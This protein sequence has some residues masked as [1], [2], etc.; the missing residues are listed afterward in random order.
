MLPE[1]QERKVLWEVK[2]LYWLDKTGA[3]KIISKS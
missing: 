3:R 1:P 2:C